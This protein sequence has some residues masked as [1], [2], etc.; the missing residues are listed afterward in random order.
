MTLEFICHCSW[1][2]S[3]F[4][5]AGGLAAAYFGQAVYRLYTKPKWWNFRHS[6]LAVLLGGAIG[7]TI[8]SM[9]MGRGAM[10]GISDVISKY[11]KPRSEVLAKAAEEKLQ[12]E[13]DD[14]RTRDALLSQL[15]H[16]PISSRS[17]MGRIDAADGEPPATADVDAQLQ[18]PA[19]GHDGAVLRP[20]AGFAYQEDPFARKAIH[21]R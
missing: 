4:G 12:L 20:E 9:E 1:I 5:L 3:Y 19:V 8:G 13:A 14:I 15:Q 18:L 16:S 2:G 6:G 17:G 21:V 11:S 7:S 10:A